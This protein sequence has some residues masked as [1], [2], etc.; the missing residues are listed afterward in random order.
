M[1]IYK[2]LAD[3]P[4]S[5]W[6]G[7]VGAQAASMYLCRP[8]FE[9]YIRTV[10]PDKDKVSILANRSLDVPGSAML[11]P[12]Y[13]QGGHSVFSPRQLCALSNFYTSHYDLLWSN[14][15]E[16]PAESFR[17]M[18]SELVSLSPAV[19]VFNISP[20][21]SDSLALQHFKEAF[22]AHRWPVQ[23]YHCFKN[24]YLENTYQDFDSYL[25]SRSTQIRKTVANRS[26]KF[27]RDP[28]SSFEI[29]TSVDKL[30]VGLRLFSTLYEKRWNNAEPFPD[31]LPGLAKVCAEKGWLRLGIAW[32]HGRPAAAQFWIIKDG[33][34]NIYKVAYDEEFTKLSVGA[35]A[36]FKMFQHVLD[37]ESV[38][39]IDFLT[40]ADGYKK[41][42]M[43]H[44]RELT[45][46]IA[47][48][49]RTV[50]G[51]LSGLRHIGGRALKKRSA[52]LAYRPLGGQTDS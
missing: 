39:E 28:S 22:G 43:S 36:L 26:R 19:D 17:G 51:A 27:D 20:C 48:N 44:S 6:N 33:I 15:E 8:W 46:L 45:G 7:V 30:E 9:N 32:I 12:L 42:W 49:R 37:N 31:F 24:L 25:A 40:G 34:A 38:H 10:V 11:L 18:V 3:V 29:I 47:F 23:E 52:R 21:R 35:V 41:D 5:L 2:C 4:E 13:E 16:F 50:R 14:G 1:T